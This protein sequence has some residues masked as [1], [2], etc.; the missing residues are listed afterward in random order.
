MWYNITAPLNDMR[1]LKLKAHPTNQMR[2]LQPSIKCSVA[3]PSIWL[4]CLNCAQ[5]FDLI[6][7]HLAVVRGWEEPPNIWLTVAKNAYF[8]GWALNFRM[9]L[10]G[11][12]IKKLKKCFCIQFLVWCKYQRYPKFFSWMKFK[13]DLQ[14]PRSYSLTLFSAFVKYSTDHKTN[15]S[16]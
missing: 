15:N 4:C 7:A 12:V 6:T 1:N 5:Q 13:Q 8:F 10:R 14:L 9:L 2:F 16:E 11:A 3:H